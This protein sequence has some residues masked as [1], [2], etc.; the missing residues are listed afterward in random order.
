M[1]IIIK[2]TYQYS[3]YPF[4]FTDDF[5]TIYH[6]SCPFS[7][8]LQMHHLNT[9]FLLLITLSSPF[10]QPPSLIPRSCLYQQLKKKSSLSIISIS[11]ILDSVHYL[12]LFF[13]PIFQ[14]NSSS[15]TVSNLFIPLFFYYP[16]SISCFVSFYL[17]SLNFMAHHCHHSFV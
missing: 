2:M 8:F 16:S 10:A 12:F 15:T 7:T 1:I 3:V 11:S 4:S 17:P 6:Y 13:Q 5:S 9:L 14:C